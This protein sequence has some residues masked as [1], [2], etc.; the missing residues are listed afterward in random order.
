MLKKHIFSSVSLVILS[1][2]FA[3]L[4]ILPTLGQDQAQPV[5]NGLLL[6]PVRFQFDLAPGQSETFELTVRNTSGGPI[7]AIGLTNDFV[8]DGESGNPKLVA[9]D[10]QETAYSI[11]NWVNGL[12]PVSLEPGEEKDVRLTITAPDDAN[13]GAHFGVVRYQVVNNNASGDAVALSASVGALIFV[14]IPGDIVEFATLEELAVA[15]D[16]KN[17]SF[18]SAAPDSVRIRLNNGGNTFVAPFG[19]VSVKDTFGNEVFAYEINNIDPRGN[20]LPDSIRE[21]EDS[22]QG[23]SSVGR[24]TVE[25][26]ISYGQGGNIISASTSFWVMPW[27][28]ILVSVTVIVI[29]VLLLTKGRS[30]YNR[31]LISSLTDRKRKS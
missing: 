5:G 9:S 22:L 4:A 30:A 29:V 10:Q 17:G 19:R 24:Y 8:A 21:F 20:V 14:E 31:R 15:K 2:F 1:S 23:I 18:F 27:S 16:G 7:S 25:A 26:S 11:R 28:V 13:P 3:L 6:S 12:D